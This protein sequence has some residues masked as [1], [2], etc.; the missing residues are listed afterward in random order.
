MK[1]ILIGTATYN[2]VTNIEI[3]INKINN[4]ELNLDIII[5]DYSSPDGTSKKIKELKTKFSNIILIKRKNKTGLDTA[6]KIIF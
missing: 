1:K 6:H 5:V 4:L 3:L 2:E